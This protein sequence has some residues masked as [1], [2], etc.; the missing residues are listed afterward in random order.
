MNEFS[1]LSTAGFFLFYSK[2][3]FKPMKIKFNVGTVLI[4][5]F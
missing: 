2:S 5:L 4:M 3:L 1:A